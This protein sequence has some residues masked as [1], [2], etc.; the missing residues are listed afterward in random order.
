MQKTIFLAS[1]KLRQKREP[2]ENQKLLDCEMEFNRRNSFNSENIFCFSSLFF[3]LLNCVFRHPQHKMQ[4]ALAQTL[5]LAV[6]NSY[7]WT[8]TSGYKFARKI[9]TF[10][11]LFHRI[12]F[13]WNKIY[14]QY[15]SL[16][17]SKGILSLFASRHQ[18]K[19]LC[20]RS[21]K[22]K[23]KKISSNTQSEWKIC[24]AI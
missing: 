22:W 23:M 4:L 20:R 19:A 15:S 18:Q 11:G 16:C 9:V 7:A 12:S 2:R 13:A 8:T 17:F 24:N 1:L 10:P 6:Q 3:L 5:F 21:E 14:F